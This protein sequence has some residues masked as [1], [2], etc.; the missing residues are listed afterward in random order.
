MI[1]AGYR[2]FG[3]YQVNYEGYEFPLGKAKDFLPSTIY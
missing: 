1:G 3:T 2:K